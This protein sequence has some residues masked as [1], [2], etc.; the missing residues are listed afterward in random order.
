[1]HRNNFLELAHLGP[2][3]ENHVRVTILSHYRKT[4]F[5]VLHVNPSTIKDKVG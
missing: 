2:F 4:A 3:L 1:M 5:V